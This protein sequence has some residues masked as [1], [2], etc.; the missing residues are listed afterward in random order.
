[1]S[2]TNL[3]GYCQPVLNLQGQTLAN[4]EKVVDLQ[5]PELRALYDSFVAGRDWCTRDGD[6]VVRANEDLCLVNGQ[7]V[8]NARP[9]NV[10]IHT[11]Q[12]LVLDWLAR[13]TGKSSGPSASAARWFFGEQ[14]VSSRDMVSQ[15]CDA[16]DKLRA[17]GLTRGEVLLIDATPKAASLVLI[18]AAWALGA[19]VAPVRSPYRGAFLQ[20][21]VEILQPTVFAFQV[22][23]QLVGL[24]T[25]I[26]C[27]QVPAD[28]SQLTSNLANTIQKVSTVAAERCPPDA[29]KIPQIGNAN[30]DDPALVLLSSGSTGLPKVVL[31]SQRACLS[32]GASFAKHVDVRAQETALT[33]LDLCTPGGLRWLA[34]L[35]LCCSSSAVVPDPE[36][37]NHPLSW[38]ELIDRH[39]VNHVSLVPSNLRS[40]LMGHK[41]V[42]ASEWQS[43]RLIHCGT[44]TLD[45]NTWERSSQLLRTTI[46]DNYG[47]NEVAG[48]LVL[49]A[50]EV[51]ARLGESGGYPFDMFV[52]V[53]DD[54]NHPCPANQE[55]WIRIYGERTMLGY[56]GDVPSL[57]DEFGW[58]KPGDRGV[59]NSAGAIRILGRGQDVI[60]NSE[61]EIVYLAQIDAWLQS[62]Q[63]VAEAVTFRVGV[64]ATGGEHIVAFI[65][66]SNANAVLQSKECLLSGLADK[67]GTAARPHQIVILDAIPKLPNQKPDRKCLAEKYQ[68]Q[69]KRKEVIL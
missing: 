61:G 49:P 53:V 22:D 62:Q 11:I 41:Y 65:S 26:A 39:K 32:L 43:V 23:E 19:V 35:P 10:S 21:I 28:L 37:H 36:T 30:L 24:P 42:D 18:W 4:S 60:K 20:A 9:V 66:R 1:M 55:G 6:L 47:C 29:N 25:S 7:V 44:G 15:V 17:L 3:Q 68:D 13:E 12:A 16:M 52:Q 57:K 31:L 27:V 5:E 38:G 48:A 33:C 64:P 59:V 54:N 69:F 50:L 56:L 14:E 8:L 46:I 67:L 51:G 34:I 58:V 2:K 63:G 40:L 45:N